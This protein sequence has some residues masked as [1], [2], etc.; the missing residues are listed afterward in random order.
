MDLYKARKAYLFDLEGSRDKSGKTVSGYGRDLEF[1]IKTFGNKAAAA[2]TYNDIAVY[3]SALK[4]RKKIKP[5]KGD[6]GEKARYSLS[7]QNR[8]RSAVRG[9]F[10]YLHATGAIP[11]NPA[12][13]IAYAKPEAAGEGDPIDTVPEYLKPAEIRSLLAAAAKSGIRDYAMF[14]FFLYT[15][16]RI[17][18]AAELKL[19]NLRD[20]EVL[21]YGKGRKT[22]KIPLKESLKS[23]LKDYMAWRNFTQEKYNRRSEFLF[24]AQKGGG[25]TTRA[26]LKRFK[27]M[28]SLAGLKDHYHVHHLRHTFGTTVYN[29][30][31]NIRVTQQ[32]LG[33]S[34]PT[35]TQIYAHTI[36]SDMKEAVESI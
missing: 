29:K 16:V 36:D 25:I 2:V 10:K 18:E 23:I 9:L 13:R 7:F 5:L 4:T 32:L 14:S 1:F 28:L 27:K 30:T 11:I 22:R 8:L 20:E 31:K 24:I 6:K 17:S 26:I 34:S 35:T 19:K 3:F 33:H 21:I 15:G 12:E